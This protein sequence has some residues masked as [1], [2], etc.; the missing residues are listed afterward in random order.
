M[1][2][3]YESTQKARTWMLIFMVAF[4]FFS[5][6]IFYPVFAS[7]LLLQPQHI[8]A[9]LVMLLVMLMF[10]Q[11]RI[12]VFADHIKLTY[13][14]GLNINLKFDRILKADPIKTPWYYGFG[15]RITPQGMLYNIQGR[16]ALV[17]YYERNG[18]PKKV[19]IGTDKPDELFKALQK[20]MK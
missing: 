19:M 4:V 14:I 20:L 18:K 9:P 6:A 5:V 12:R 8:L 11:L 10:Y 15:I 17:V 16:T 13:G 2:V 3:L 7:D 1:K